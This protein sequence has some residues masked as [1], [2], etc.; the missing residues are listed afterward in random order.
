MNYY[1]V[2]VRSNRYHGNE[3]LTYASPDKLKTGSIV[4]VELQKTLVIG[5]ISG[6]C[7]K[8][9]FQTKPIANLL[10]DHTVPLHLVRLCE[11][12]MQYYPAP[13][14]M[15]TQ[16]ILPTKL[17]QREI[18]QPKDLASVDT[19]LNGLP[20]L[21]NEQVTT[22]ENLKNSDTN[23]LHGTTGSGKTRIYIELAAKAVKE[24]KSAIILTPE[25]S[26]ITQLSNRF[27]QVFGDLVVVMHSKQ[28]P[29]QRQEAWLKCLESTSPVVIIGPRSALFAPVE[30]PGLI[31]LDE[32][33]ETA[34]KQDQAPQYQTGRVAAFLAKLTR[35]TL[36]LGSATPLVSDYY[37]AQEKSKPIIE[38][39]QLAQKQLEAGPEIVVV[40]RRDHSL[41]NRSP[42]LSQ[43]L[44]EEIESSLS[45][46]EQSLLYLN[47]RGTA[48]LVMCNN[49]GWQ[50]LCPHCDIPLTYHGD[51]HKV[52]CHSC[53]YSDNAP[54]N[55][56]ECNNPDMVFK[57][58]GTKAIALE[59]QRIFPHA[60]I[61]RFDTDN[62]KADSF[63][64]NFEKAFSGE[65]DILIGTQMLAKGLDLPKLSLVG[66]LLADTSLYIPDYTA[67]ER[68]FELINQVLGRIGRGHVAGKAVIQTYNPD[69]AVLNYAINNDYAGFFKTEIAA[70]KEFLFPPFC[71]ILKL[72]ARRASLRSVESAADQ[73]KSMI[74]SNGYKVRVEGPA[75]AFHER[76][77]GKYQWQLIVKSLERSE[78]IKII[79]DLPSNWSYDIDPM[80]LL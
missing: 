1:S 29:K 43:K 35:A 71:H 69:N 46:A 2:W 9:K 70:R 42:Y 79:K 31:V 56:P 64:E 66:V 51:S 5:V 19:K 11:W 37:M 25:I 23:I 22:L 48:R 41:F 44:I 16:Q 67:Q 8:P 24:N 17:G 12:M 61:G 18:E 52:R 13:L 7:D 76:F 80:D 30:N 20:P 78:L 68:T 72:S 49:C 62:L 39:K 47:R 40:D 59:V 21:T 15:I 45:K 3:P 33:H 77:Q 4:E 14:G 75:P 32:E 57:T 50:S 27:S 34:Y 38:M 55:C 73:L 26:L 58:A 65:I 36:V 10:S 54:V 74:E 53:N 6:P 28:T 60:R 63:E